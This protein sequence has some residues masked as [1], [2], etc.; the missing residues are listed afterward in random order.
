VT[1]PGYD[2][3][4]ELEPVTVEHPP[5]A[6]QVAC[7][8][9]GLQGRILQAPPTYS[10]VKIQGVPAYKLAKK[11]KITELAPKPVTIHWLV[12]RRY[13]WPE[14]EFEV[15][16]GRGTYVRSLIR[17]WGAALHTG[18]CLTSLRRLSVGP[19]T[20]DLAHTPEQIKREALDKVLIPC[21]QAREMIAR[22]ADVVPPRP[23]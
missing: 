9:G 18:G 11:N 20:T 7:A 5:T 1:N 2:M 19:F 22:S 17:D 8:A 12:V 15:A 10:S 21:E 13:C 16:C 6:E 23:A 4:M 3:E 14:L